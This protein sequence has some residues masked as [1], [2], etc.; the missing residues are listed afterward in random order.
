MLVFSVGTGN[1]LFGPF[2]YLESLTFYIFITFIFFWLLSRLFR[3]VC[4]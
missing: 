3:I 1:G 4:R 2:K